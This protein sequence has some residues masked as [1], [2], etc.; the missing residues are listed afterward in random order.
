MV[1]WRGRYGREVD[2]AS[3]EECEV[4]EKRYIVWDTL[5]KGFGLRVN[6]D[7]SKT[8]L[9]KYALEGADVAHDRQARFPLDP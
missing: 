4:R 2:P 3:G 1:A 8:Y 6:V 5:T 7:G 9:L